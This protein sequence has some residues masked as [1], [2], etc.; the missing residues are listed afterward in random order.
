MD[1]RSGWL[2]KLIYTQEYGF[3]SHLLLDFHFSF[4]LFLHFV[5]FAMKCIFAISYLIHSFQ[6]FSLHSWT[7][8]KMIKTFGQQELLLEV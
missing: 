1:Q 2:G 8:E 4:S 6:F 3:A 7:Q 5:L